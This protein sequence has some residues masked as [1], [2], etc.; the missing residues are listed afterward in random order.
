MLAQEFGLSQEFGLVVWLKVQ[1]DL[2]QGRDAHTV[3]AEAHI[4]V[5]LIEQ[6]QRC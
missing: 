3:P 6:K 4:L 1:K 5:I 2:T